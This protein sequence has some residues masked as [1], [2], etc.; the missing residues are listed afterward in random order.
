M[1]NYILE[2]LPG[3]EIRSVSRKAKAISAKLGRI[4]KFDFNGIQCLVNAKT[5]ID[6]LYR[7]YLNAL[8][9]KW[10]TIG[11]NPRNRYSRKQLRPINRHF[12][13]AHKLA[14]IRR[15]EWEAKDAAEKLTFLQRTAGVTLEITNQEAWDLGKANNQDGYGA[16]IYEYAEGWAKL[17]QVELSQGKR[18]EDIASPTSFQLGFLGITGFMYGAAVSVLSQ[19]W[20]NGEALRK[21]HNKSYGQEGDGVVNPAVLTLSA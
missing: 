3:N 16:A 21:W 19:C 20:K 17:M 10:V 1:E 13:K 2:A 15:R 9:M 8:T 4:V 12:R 7:D 11:P 18:L 14:A 5:N 6:W